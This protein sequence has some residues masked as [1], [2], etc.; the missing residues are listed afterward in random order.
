ME[1]PTSTRRQNDLAILA[2]INKARI[3]ES[4]GPTDGSVDVAL[5]AS[6]VQDRRGDLFDRDAG[7]VQHRYGFAL[8][9]QLGLTHLVSAVVQRGV[10]A[11]RTALLA[12]LGQAL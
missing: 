1:T 10:L 11:L 9:E 6:P 3:P 8:H 7:G 12:Y 2:P 5:E 4:P